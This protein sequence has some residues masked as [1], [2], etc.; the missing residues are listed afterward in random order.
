MAS[1]ACRNCRGQFDHLQARLAAGLLQQILQVASR[2]PPSTQGISQS[3]SSACT[4]RNHQPE[5]L[6]QHRLFEQ[7]TTGE[8]WRA[9]SALSSGSPKL[10]NRGA[11]WRRG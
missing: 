4:G 11:L 10:C 5:E 9:W 3:A 6:W 1:L 8:Q 7:G 2:T